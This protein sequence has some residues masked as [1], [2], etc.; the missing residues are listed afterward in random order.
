MSQYRA[1]LAQDD[2]QARQQV[3]Q[4]LRQQKEVALA[5]ELRKKIFAENNV[6]IFFELPRSSPFSSF[7][8]GRNSLTTLVP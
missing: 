3:I 2:A 7:F 4:A 5:E 8:S 6:E 1:Q